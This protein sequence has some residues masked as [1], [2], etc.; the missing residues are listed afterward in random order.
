NDQRAAGV[1]DAAPADPAAAAGQACDMPAVSDRQPGD[2]DSEPLVDNVKDP[3]GVVAAD[4]QQAG[5]RAFDVQ[6]LLD[7]QF[8]AG[9]GNGLAVEAGSED[10]RI[11]ALGVLDGIAER[12]RSAVDVVEDGQ[13]AGGGSIF[14]HF[15]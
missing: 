11:A 14:E 5:A 1:C 2:G 8:V 3:E 9:Q 7:R 4:G 12:A 13:R 10:N 15:E 6:A